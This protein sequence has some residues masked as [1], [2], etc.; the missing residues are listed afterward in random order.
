MKVSK[1]F[2][3]NMRLGY[4]LKRY[5]MTSLFTAKSFSF[6]ALV[7]WESDV[8]LSIPVKSKPLLTGYWKHIFYNELETKPNGM[9]IRS[10]DNP[11]SPYWWFQSY[12]LPATPLT[13][14]PK[15]LCVHFSCLSWMLGN[16]GFS[17]A[18]LISWAFRIGYGLWRSTWLVSSLFSSKSSLE[19]YI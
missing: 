18:S 6:S 2:I 15:L 5:K 10:V 7:I 8:G 12:S 4:L 11:C 9:Y 19:S 14:K 16:E 1:R 3:L 13:T 17:S